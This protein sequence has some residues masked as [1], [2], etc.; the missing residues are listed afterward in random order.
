MRTGA[1]HSIAAGA[2]LLILVAA[3]G[4]CWSGQA[5]PPKASG[6]PPS[7]AQRVYLATALA[8]RFLGREDVSFTPLQVSGPGYAV[9]VQPTQASARALREGPVYHLT[10]DSRRG[11]SDRGF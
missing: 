8:C 1:R 10:R 9:T 6:T 5:A 4:G 3:L 7:S 2:S 11:K